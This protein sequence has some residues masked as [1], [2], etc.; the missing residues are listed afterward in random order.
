[1]K[2]TKPKWKKGAMCRHITWKG[3]MIVEK[4]L[5]YRLGVWEYSLV[6]LPK[7]DGTSTYQTNAFESELYEI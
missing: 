7:K 6:S 1:M 2:K 4:I 3:K 5:R